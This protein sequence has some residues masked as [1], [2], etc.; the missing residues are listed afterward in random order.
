MGTFP[1]REVL[2]TLT[3]PASFRLGS[4]PSESA[5][6]PLT[7]ASRTMSNTAQADP[8]T[9]HSRKRSRV[10][11]ESLLKIVSKNVN[12]TA[13]VLPKR[14]PSE[15]QLL[16]RYKQ[17]MVV[18]QQAPQGSSPFVRYSQKTVGTSS[19]FSPSTSKT[20]ASP[21]SGLVA[22][23]ASPQAAPLPTQ[24]Q[25]LFSRNPTYS[26]TTPLHSR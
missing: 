1:T 17:E 21:V 18:S 16:A 15:A 23:T 19:I 26:I 2:S 9:T 8:K 3:R 5:S 24:Q 13:P 22:T 11:Y 4:L 20:Y 12:N 7:S 10:I 25:G 14:Q 6:H